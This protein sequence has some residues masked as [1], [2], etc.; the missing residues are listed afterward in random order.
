MINKPIAIIFL[1]FCPYLLHAQFKK[2]DRM[3]GSGIASAFYNSAES[4]ASIGGI[5]ATN[6]KVRGWGVYVN[7][8]LGF[9]LSDQIVVGV[10]FTANPTGQKT[11][12]EENGM[13]FQR[14]EIN[15]FNIGAGGFTRY[16]FKNSGALLPFAQVSI[17]AGI[18]STSVE[19][20][21][22]GGSGTSAYKE[23]YSG[24]SSGGFFTNSSFSL[25]LT[26]MISPY[27]GVDLFL[28]YNYSYNKHSFTKTTWKDL[29]IDGIMDEM[30]KNETD[31]KY[32]NHGFVIGLG[33]QVFIAAKKK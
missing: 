33:F 26:K 13:T 5:G 4:D 23:T 11:S 6:A 32:T 21:F 19:G 16:Y 3:V 1:V 7:P 12:Y 27:T 17:N 28:G 20:F 31:N 15:S 22:Y 25:G 29:Q 30:Y 18:S 9:F 2:G 8:Q 24:K 10:S 14:D